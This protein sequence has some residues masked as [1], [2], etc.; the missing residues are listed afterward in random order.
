MV[1]GHFK[2]NAKRTQKKLSKIKLHACFETDRNTTPV[3]AAATTPPSYER[4]DHAMGRNFS[5]FQ[6]AHDAPVVK[7][8]E[9]NDQTMGT[10]LQRFV[11]ST[12]I[13]SIIV[14]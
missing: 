10:T 1:R 7:A 5:A 2:N 9:T 12:I 3:A 11:K 14:A 6:E 8:G 4:T 13:K